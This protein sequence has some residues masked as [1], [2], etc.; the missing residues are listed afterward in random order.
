MIRDR[1]KSISPSMV[2]ALTG[3]WLA[4]NQTLAPAQLFLG[5]ALGLIIAA[6]SATLRPL[7]S[8]VRRVDLAALLALTV[9]A[10]VVKSN[11][12]VGRIVLGL[13]RNRP[14]RSGF[15]DIPLDLR[16]PHGLAALA[17]IVTATPGTVWAGHST[18]S[19]WL[20]L[21]VLDLDDEQ[22]WVRYIKQ[23]FEGPLIRIFE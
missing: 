2:A 22:R 10:E 20:K 5:L 9:F 1:L 6:A 21:H 4:L 18:D 11:I 16:D 19:G 23:R 12:S 17:V 7:R 3:L 14:L 15:V 13:P 8:T